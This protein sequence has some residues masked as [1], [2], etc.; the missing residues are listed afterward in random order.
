MC[1]TQPHNAHTLCSA[2]VALAQQMCTQLVPHAESVRDRFERAF[3]LFGE[4]HTMYNK[5]GHVTHR[6]ADSL[7][8]LTQTYDLH[9]GYESYMVSQFP[10]VGAAIN[11]FMWYYRTTFPTATIL[12]KLHFLEDHAVDFIKKWGTGFG[13]L[14]EQGGESVHA[15][16]NSLQRAYNNTP[17]GV[18]RL[19]HMVREHHLRLCPENLQ[20]APTPFKRKKTE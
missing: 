15:V 17:N 5:A 2:P 10:C 19:F 9:A 7:G 18:D 13:F 3:L 12:P 16:L 1:S 8:K 11:H 6:E 14:G 4:C 20:E